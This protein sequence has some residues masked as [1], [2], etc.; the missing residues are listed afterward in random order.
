MTQANPYPVSSRNVVMEAHADQQRNCGRV[1]A[2][3]PEQ[4]RDT[5]QDLPIGHLYFDRL[6]ERLNP[7][8]LISNLRAQKGVGAT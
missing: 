5:L 1:S 2:R 3:Q 6:R 7:E 4:V 8:K